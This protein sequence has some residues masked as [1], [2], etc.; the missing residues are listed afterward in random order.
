MII[1]HIDRINLE[2]YEI[3]AQNIELL[4]EAI[5]IDLLSPT[6]EENKMID[7]ALNIDIPTSE[8]MGKIRL[9]N[10][11]Y[12]Q[13]N[14]IF[15]IA[16][17]ISH[18]ESNEP[19]ID[20]VSFVLTPNK[21][22]TVRYADPKTFSI[23]AGQ[24]K[25]I[26]RSQRTAP[27]LFTE[28]LHSSI[29]RLADILSIVGEHLEDYSKFIFAPPVRK[30]PRPDYRK[31]MRELGYSADLATKARESLLAFSRLIYFFQQNAG[32]RIDAEHNAYL[33]T[34]NKD[35]QALGAHAEFQSNKIN[36]LL[37][38]T[39]GSVNIAQNNTIKTFSVAAVSF[40]PPTLVASVY[41]MNFSRDSPFN[42]PE[43]G[44]EYGYLYAL[45]LMIITPFA[46]FRYFKYR[47][48][49]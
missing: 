9:S 10:T 21:L 13:D 36:Y 41:G 5:W 7:K 48:W 37:A 24:L 30:G 46:L 19:K 2:S 26:D 4:N 25:M 23:F 12:K 18:S 27:I 35:I 45:T 15:M 14:N 38:A 16:T 39:L 32:N 40:L 47:G 28:L 33:L 49:F 1:A 17:M 8:E 34:L 44:W 11:L 43:L 29:N 22:I 20:P 6:V 42:M 31:N 3:T